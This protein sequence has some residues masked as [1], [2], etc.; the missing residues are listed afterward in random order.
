MGIFHTSPKS[1]KMDI[2]KV[3]ENN[4]KW[5]ANFIIWENTDFVPILAMV[6]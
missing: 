3:F 2:S 6:I 4:E 5:I 1:K